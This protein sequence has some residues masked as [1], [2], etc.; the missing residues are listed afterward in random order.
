MDV[1]ETEKEIEIAAELPGLQE[2]EVG[3]T[4]HR[5]GREEGREE[6]EGQELFRILTRCL[7]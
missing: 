1:A 3:R 7:G 4:S 6:G 2:D 5:Q